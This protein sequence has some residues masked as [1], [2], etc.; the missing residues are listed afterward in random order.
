LRLSD[1]ITIGFGWR[2]QQRVPLLVDKNR[3]REINF[4]GC[5]LLAFLWNDLGQAS[6]PCK[7]E[8]RDG[9][10]QT[11]R[12]LRR[13]HHRAEF[14]HRLVPIARR[15]RI[16]QRIGGRLQPFPA[17]TLPPIALPPPP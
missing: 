1:V 4:L 17:P 10:D 8:L 11:L 3:S 15:V 12:R 6:L 13:A 5:P 2:Q 7:A 9:T 14:H 16:E